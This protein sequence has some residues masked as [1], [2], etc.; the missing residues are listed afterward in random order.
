MLDAEETKLRREAR[1]VNVQSWRDMPYAKPT[2]TK[3]HS[4][5]FIYEECPVCTDFEVGSRCPSKVKARSSEDA[6]SYGDMRIGAWRGCL[7]AVNLHT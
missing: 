7:G 1:H 5:D 4:R 2:P 3:V 6:P